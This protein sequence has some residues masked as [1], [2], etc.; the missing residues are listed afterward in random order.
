MGSKVSFSEAGYSIE[1]EFQ[2]WFLQLVTE[3]R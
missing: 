2:I 3:R 1:T